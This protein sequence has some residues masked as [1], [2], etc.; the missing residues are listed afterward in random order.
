MG[1]RLMGK[2]N[3]VERREAREREDGLKTVMVSNAKRFERLYADPVSR[4]GGS[5]LLRTLANGAISMADVVPVVGSFVSWTAD[6]AKMVKRG[7]DQTRN[8]LSTTGDWMASWG[9]RL[10][11]WGRVGSSIGETLDGRGKQV[12]ELSKY[13]RVPSFLDLTP[14]VSLTIAIIPGVLEIPT[15]GVMP[16]H[17]LESLLQLKADWPRMKAG[18]A[19][20]REL[21]NHEIESYRHDSDLQEAMKVFTKRAL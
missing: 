5:A 17:W 12:K 13:F 7:S 4:E 11:P 16:T 15:G 2:E 19:R 1:E 8:F 10:K 9:K 18:Y 20:A 21:W 14:D 3:V 6:V